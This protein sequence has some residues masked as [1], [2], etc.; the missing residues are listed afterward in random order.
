MFQ[1][2]HPIAIHASEA[3]LRTMPSNY[4][5]DDIQAVLVEGKWV[6]AHKDGMPY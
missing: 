5:D 1:E 4:P 3:S 2:S 6:F